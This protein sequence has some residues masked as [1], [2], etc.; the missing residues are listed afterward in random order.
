MLMTLW[1]QSTKKIITVYNST[2]INR[3][4][5]CDESAPDGPLCLP[6]LADIPVLPAHCPC[7]ALPQISSQLCG[8]CLKTP[9][10]F[11]R[12][13]TGFYYQAP[14]SGFIRG[15]KYK[16]QLH[17]LP[18]L[19]DQLLEPLEAYTFDCVIP[20]PNHWTRT[21]MRGR[22]PSLELAQRLSTALD[23]PL[24]LALRRTRPT[25]SQQGLNRQQRLRNL[26]QAFHIRHQRSGQKDATLFT[27]K[28]KDVLLVDDVVTTATTADLAAR[29]LK[30]AGARS[31]TVACLARTPERHH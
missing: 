6:C 5:L 1:N 17:L 31:V 7:C 28:G 13:V 3:C 25:K 11:D 26:K 4:Q 19:V 2:I 20:V 30:S 24:N 29:T 12:M 15:W 21:L 18:W 27:I 10:P 16:R 22:Y 8:A 14:I 9:P 23:T